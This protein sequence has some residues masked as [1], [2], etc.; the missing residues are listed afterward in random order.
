TEQLLAGIFADVLGVE[1][2]GVTQ[3]FFTDLGGDSI[4][5]I[6]VVARANRAGLRLR[7]KQLFD[8]QS[9]AE[10]AVVAERGGAVDAE[11]GLV[12]G[13]VPLTPVARRFFESNPVDP[14]HFNQA[15]LLEVPAEL[16]ARALDRAVAAMFAHHDALRL[17]FRRADGVWRQSCAAIAGT[18]RIVRLDLSAV[19][20]A[21]QR[22]ALERANAAVQQGFDLAAGP[23]ARFVHV[24][25]GRA[26]PGRLLIAAHHLAVDGV[27]W[28]I[29]LEDL[30][31]AYL[32]C[33]SQPGAAVQLPPKTTSFK[34]WAEALVEFAASEQALADAPYWLARDAG[35]ARRLPADAP[36]AP[37]PAGAARTHT[38]SLTRDETEALLERVARAYR[39]EINDALLSALA[40]A[41][42]QWTGSRSVS[43]E[44]EGHGREELHR[45]LDVSRTVG[46]FTSHFPVCLELGAALAPDE[47]LKSVKEQL[48]AVPSRGITYSVLRYLA[49]DPELAS[50]LAA[51]PRPSVAFNYLGQ[52]DHVLAEDSPFRPAGERLGPLQSPR[53]VRS[54]TLYIG[55]NV[56]GACLHVAFTYGS[57]R[58]DAATIERLAADYLHALRALIA[59][60][61]DS[62][63]AAFTP[64]DFPL[65]SLDSGA[66]EAVFAQLD[67]ADR[68]AAA[69]S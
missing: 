58:F 31:A 48:R 50:R 14:Q 23:I 10:L 46:W 36:D 68:S 41:L 11:Q 7:P 6:R 40:A 20:S 43:I 33:V 12:T 29:L 35:R 44:L 3:N 1:R 16:D 24:D 49:N 26:R 59:H 30:Q 42:A 54:H 34:E 15:V 61:T 28:R 45:E 4:L 8:Y 56:S 67:A 32:Q 57:G 13:G 53:A 69:G 52:F 66:L 51:Q 19:G 37:D 64:S 65:A 63:S 38:V 27:S 60:C 25:L 2:V 22:D 5:G 9:I 17:R 47:V 18:D 21:A 39:T 62:A 55:A